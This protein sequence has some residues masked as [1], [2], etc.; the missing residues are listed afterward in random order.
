MKYALGLDIGGTRI[1]AGAVGPDGD[2]LHREVGAT[3][4][5]EG[6]EAL[7][8]RVAEMAGRF[9]EKLGAR[10]EGIGLGLSGAVDPAVGVV[11]LPGKFKGL[12][13]FPIV[14][15]LAEKTGVRVIADNDARACL[16][17]E[18]RY[19]SAR[20]KNWVVSITIGTGI[21]SG[22]LLDGKI[23]RDPH[24]MFGTQLGHLV[25]QAEGGKLCL[26]NAHGTGESLCSATALAMAV[27]D[28]L[29]RGIPSVLTDRYFEDPMS[30]DFAAVIEGIEAGDRLCI[31]CFE[32]WRERL[33]W[34]LVN[35]VHAYAPELIVIGGGGAHAAEHFLD[36]LRDHIRS[37][38]FRY[39]PCE[40]FPIEISTLLEDAGVLG[41]A[42]L[43]WEER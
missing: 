43:V 2:I 25:I 13:G 16:L 12:E 37:H 29:Q 35:A 9:A 18:C 5:A 4:A 31:H 30:I 24:L 42:A 32:Q 7:L 23:L 36:F 14:P 8:A 3:A 17:A 6:A 1:K 41:A 22:V 39:P 28:G 15:R 10:P 34:I 26:T 20:G 38:M 33:G 19:G 40:T 21:G 11:Y 27:R